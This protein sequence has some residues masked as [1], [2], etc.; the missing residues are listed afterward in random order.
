MLSEDCVGLEE[1]R[2]R[3]LAV[4]PEGLILLQGVRDVRG[5]ALGSK[6]AA[7]ANK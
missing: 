3:V 2:L 6:A 7:Q 1:N 4:Y 5:T